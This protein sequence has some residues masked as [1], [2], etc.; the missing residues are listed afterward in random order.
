MCDLFTTK[1]W[2]KQQSWMKYIWTLPKKCSFLFKSYILKAR[3]LVSVALSS[4]VLMDTIDIR[5][6][7]FLFLLLCCQVTKGSHVE[8][9]IEECPSMLGFYM[10]SLKYVGCWVLTCRCSRKQLLEGIQDLLKSHLKQLKFLTAVPCSGGHLY[11][12][13]SLLQ[14]SPLVEYLVQQR[15]AKIPIYLVEKLPSPRDW[16]HCSSNFHSFSQTP[17][18]QTAPDTMC[19]YSQ[20]SWG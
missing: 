4:I 8:P 15:S 19:C 3:P 13:L 6:P 14:N 7:T 5:N 20:Q 18:H 11:F 10:L 2:E 12:L 16:K 17:W 1:L 9:H